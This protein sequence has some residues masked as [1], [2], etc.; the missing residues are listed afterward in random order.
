MTIDTAGNV[1]A[2]PAGF[3]WEILGGAEDNGGRGEIDNI[4]DLIESLDIHHGIK[5]SLRAKFKWL[6]CRDLH[7]DKH[8]DED[9]DDHRGRGHGKENK[10]KH[11]KKNKGQ[12]DDKFENHG[13]R[14]SLI[15]L[16]NQVMAQRGKQIS[17]FHADIF[18][19]ELNVFINGKDL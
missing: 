7:D 8:E 19:A 18:I 12:H 16:I 13:P 3:S 17:F 10:D 5:N 15:G 2:T 14:N 1:D 4:C 11:G 6:D 9:D